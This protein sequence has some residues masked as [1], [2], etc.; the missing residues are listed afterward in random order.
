MPPAPSLPIPSMSKLRRQK[1]WRELDGPK[2][3][4]EMSV[5]V[6]VARRDVTLTLQSAVG[7]PKGTKHTMDGACRDIFLA[8]ACQSRWVHIIAGGTQVCYL[9]FDMGPSRAWS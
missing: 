4:P 1:R 3:N 9:V 5:G 2:V 7:N 8:G 6:A